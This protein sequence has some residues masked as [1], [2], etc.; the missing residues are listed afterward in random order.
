MIETVL[1]AAFWAALIIG[2]VR[3]VVSNF[4]ERRRLDELVKRERDAALAE[5]DRARQAWLS[6]RT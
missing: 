6:L 1:L 4:Q 5:I 2:G 3:F